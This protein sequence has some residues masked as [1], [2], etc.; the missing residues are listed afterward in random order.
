MRLKSII[1][2]LYYKLYYPFRIRQLRNQKIITV[3]FKIENLGAWKS[4]RLYRQ[5][6]LHPRFAPKLYISRNLD[7]D[8]R[9]NLRKYCVERGYDYLEIDGINHT[10]WDYCYPDIVFFQKPY[11]DT[12]DG[13]KHLLANRK[14]L[15][16]YIPY[17]FHGS[18]EKWSFDWPYLHKCWQV[19]YENEQL[20][21]EYGRLLNSRFP[22]SYASGLPV[23]DELLAPKETIS[24][25]WKGKSAGKKR[26]IYAPHHSINPENE[27]KTSTFLETGEKILEL[28]EKYS[29]KVQWAFKPHPL[30][31][32]KLEKVWGKGKT[33]E[34]YR[35]W[36]DASWSQF[37]PGKYLGLFKHSDAMIHDCGSFI[38]EYLYTGN[39]VM[40][41]MKNEK[42]EETFNSAHRRALS[43]HYHAWNINDVEKFIIDVIAGI[44]L[45]RQA[46]DAFKCEYLTPPNNASATQNIIDC[47][48]DKNASKKMLAVLK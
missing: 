34:Y 41:L 18:I 1:G 30:L 48:L 27:W 26:I 29:D 23:M 38:M 17:A 13:M 10:V 15:F 20:A 37:E 39:P 45:K 42:L 12:F 47:I 24:D 36:S 40:Y 21:Q 7:E 32:D 43:L 28:A 25:Q 3:V 2:N 6:L 31:R 5:M 44:D 14:T 11:R 16:A 22:N 8:D 46:R 33:D 4:E 9:I 35:R 19:Y